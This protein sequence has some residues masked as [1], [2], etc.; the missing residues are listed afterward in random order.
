VEFADGLSSYSVQNIA[1]GSEHLLVTAKDA[2]NQTSVFS[3]G[4]N[5]DGQLG[6]GHNKNCGQLTKVSKIAFIAICYI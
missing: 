2:D 5:K 1:C 4:L 6:L 3:C